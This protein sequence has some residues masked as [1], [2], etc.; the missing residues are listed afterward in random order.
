MT[1]AARS[2]RALRPPRRRSPGPA[3]SST[4]RNGEPLRRGHRLDGAAPVDDARTSSTTSAPASCTACAA[5]SS[6]VPRVTVSSVTTTLSPGSSA[7]AIRPP[8]PWSFASLRT[9]NALS[10]RPRVAADAGGDEGDGVGAHGQPADGGRLGGITDEHG[11]GHQQHGLGAAHRLLGVDEPG[12]LAPRLEGEVAPRLTECS[13]R[14]A[15]S[16][17]TVGPP[18]LTRSARRG[19]RRR[20]PM[21]RRRRPAACSVATR[22]RRRAAASTTSDHADA[23][24]EDAVHLVARRPSPA[25]GSPRRSRASIPGDRSSTA[26]RPSGRHAG[27]LPTMPPAGDVGARR[28]DAAPVGAARAQHGRG[29]DHRRAA[30]ARRPRVRVGPVPG[31]LVEVRARRAR[32]ARGAPACSRWTADPGEASPTSASPAR[33]RAGPSWV[34]LH[35]ADG[36]AGQVELVGRHD[37][38]VLGRLAADQGAAGLPAALVHAGDDGRRRARGPPCRSPCSRA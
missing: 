19:P 2:R 26:P 5:S 8:P 3:P 23:P 31:R 35:H 9:L 18:A 25:A 34:P 17:S 7:P 15:R 6:D 10:G 32:A 12:A 20:S 36:E 24:V 28:A 27:R 1:P 22:R 14:C 29:V 11:V 38:G 30:A 16:A 21:T 13:S 37:A 33:T 4:A